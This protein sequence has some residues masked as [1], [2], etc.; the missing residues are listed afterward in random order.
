M[1]DGWDKTYLLSIPIEMCLC[2]IVFILDLLI[3][4]TPGK[5]YSTHGCSPVSD[6]HLFRRWPPYVLPVGSTTRVHG[7]QLGLWQFSGHHLCTRESRWPIGRMR[8]GNRTI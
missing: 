5:K 3:G 6:S 8:Y 1:C 4:D 7:R 2:F